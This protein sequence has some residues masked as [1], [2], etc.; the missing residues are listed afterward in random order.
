[1]TSNR[2]RAAA[3]GSSITAEYLARSMGRQYA[4]EWLERRAEGVL[5]MPECPYASPLLRKEWDKGFW[6]EVRD[7]RE[8]MGGD[9][10]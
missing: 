1:M 9:Y 6:F 3:A 10:A 7:R 5:L 8:E 4:Q 2:V